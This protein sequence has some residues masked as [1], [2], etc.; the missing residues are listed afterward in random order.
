MCKDDVIALYDRHAA[1]YD[2]DRGRSLQERAWLNRFL[3]HVRDGG[4]IL[5][6]GCGMGEPMAR[7]FVDR[8][9]A[10]LGVDA[11]PAMIDLCRARF[12]DSEWIV[13]DMRSLEIHRRFD[14]ILAWDSTFHLG[15]DDQRGMFLRFASHAAEGAPLMF[16]SGNED[17]EV[18]GSYQDEPLYHASLSSAEY[19]RLLSANGFEVQAHVVSDPECGGHTVWLATYQ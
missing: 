18:V 10:V 19:T 1:A 7:Y 2:H 6:V 3:A 14:G 16:T 11:S 4:T 17:G 5:D 9:F 12:P 8:G 13:A 15:R